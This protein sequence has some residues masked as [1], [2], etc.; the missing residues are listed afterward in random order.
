MFVMLIDHHQLPDAQVR[1]LAELFVAARG[2]RF[3]EFALRREQARRLGENAGRDEPLA[4]VVQHRRGG[5][6][7]QFLAR[8]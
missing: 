3:D 4:D 6:L 5:D 8:R 7:L 1:S 2:V